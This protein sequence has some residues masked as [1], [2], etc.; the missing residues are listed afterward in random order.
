MLDIENAIFEKFPHFK[1]QPALIRNST[2]GLLK[3]VVYQDKVNQFLRDHAGL[4]GVDFIDAIFDYFNFSYSV[5][6]RERANIPAEGRLV[7]VANHPIG[8]LDGL[9][10][11]KLISE[12]R[13]DV[14]ILANDMLMHFTALKDLLIPV[15]TLGQGGA[16]VRS[17]KNVLLALQKEQAIIIFPAGEVSRAQAG[18]V[19]DGTWRPGFL[20][21][22]RR[23]QA[24]VLPIHI[25][26]KNSWMFYS[27]S[28]IFKPLGTALLAHEMFNKHS[29]V[30]HF[31]IGE[32]INPS[33]L[34]S[35]Q[36]PDRALIKRL[37]KHL[38]KIG[39]GKNPIFVTE[40]TIA[41][42]EP[43]DALQHELRDAQL[44]GET[45]DGNRIYLLDYQPNSSVMREI[46]RLREIAFRKVGEGTGAKR[47]IDAFDQHYKHLV[48][49]D[50]ENLQIAGAYRIG[51]GK[52]LLQ[53][54]GIDGFYTRS[55]YQYREEFLTYLQDGIE[56]GRSF[57]NPDYW[58][59]ASLDYLWQG[60]G[61]YLTAHPARYLVGPV[62][63]S[64][65]YPAHL[66]D[67]LVIFFTTY[68]RHPQPLVSAKHPY[69]VN[70]LREMDFT[71]RLAGLSADQALRLLQEEFTAAGHKLP[72]LFKQYL[73]LFNPG[74]FLALEFSLD[75]DFGDCLDGL[76]LADMQKIKPEK[77]RRY[78]APHQ[79]SSK[80]SP[81]ETPA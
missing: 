62:S 27:A 34:E 50:R 45:Q 46:G 10:L 53:Q 56:L 81:E 5:S 72:V 75:P 78:L 51:E 71:Q 66:M 7:V 57:V 63:M 79:G 24:P 70:P 33:Q 6:Q 16:S 64:A 19:K 30:I 35:T 48:L 17:I 13:R 11:I 9:A 37:K 69:Q 14:K 76:C 59:K 8:S 40:K 73:A 21:L 29:K 74:G 25:G 12:V 61:A 32:T 43:R 55:L 77:A 4:E 3:K 2:L 44:L 54:F 31:R 36:L 38:Y 58:G 15:D 47:D 39:K 23:A 26:A 18:G 49:W 42:P 60:I 41:H 1:R 80:T 52:A 68:Y 65:R 20:Q 28:F 22:A 67:K